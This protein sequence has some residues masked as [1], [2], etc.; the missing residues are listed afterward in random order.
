MIEKARFYLNASYFSKIFKE[1]LGVSYTKYLMEFRVNKAAE[2]I[3][4]RR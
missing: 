3:A 4:T 2:L 1:E